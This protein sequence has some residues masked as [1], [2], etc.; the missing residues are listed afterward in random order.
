ME[1]KFSEFSQFKESYKSLNHKLMKIE[2][3]LSLAGAV[4]VSLAVVASWSLAKKYFTEFAEHVEKTQISGGSGGGASSPNSFNFMQILGKFGKMTCWHPFPLENCRP[5]LGEILDP[6]LQI[7][8][9][10][11]VS[12]RVNHLMLLQ[13]N[14][15][16][17]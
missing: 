13:L 7:D 10:F 4:N 3:P 6:P 17:Y 14:M 1:G 9:I 5:H 12:N 11:H 2:D 16:H 15:L 8:V